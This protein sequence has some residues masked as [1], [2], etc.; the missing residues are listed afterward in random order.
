MGPK[1][2]Y[3]PSSF[4]NHRFCPGNFATEVRK[5]RSMT[6]R[7]ES[8]YFSDPVQRNGIKLLGNA[9]EASMEHLK[10]MERRAIN[11]WGEATG[12]NIPLRIKKICMYNVS[13][14]EQIQ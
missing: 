8:E 6:Q 14:E 10:A 11:L 5:S 2:I 12:R 4:S 13:S 9:S 7:L 3:N 1:Q